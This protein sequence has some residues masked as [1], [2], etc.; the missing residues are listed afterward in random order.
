MHQRTLT[1]VNLPD[2]PLRFIDRFPEYHSIL[3]DK[4]QTDIYNYSGIFE[5]NLYTRIG[6]RYLPGVF[7]QIIS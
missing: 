2:E 1:P 3:R 5:R 4:T 6:L 7:P